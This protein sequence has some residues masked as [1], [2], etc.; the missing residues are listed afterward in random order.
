[1]Q[2]IGRA[3]CLAA[4]EGGMQLSQHLHP[5]ILVGSTLDRQLLNKVYMCVCVCVCVCVRVCMCVCES[6]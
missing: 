6:K 2:G 3:A 5:H 4:G 1:V